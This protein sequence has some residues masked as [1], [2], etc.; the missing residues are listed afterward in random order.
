MW[1]EVRFRAGTASGHSLPAMGKPK[2]RKHPITFLRA[3]RKAGD[4][5]LKDAAKAIGMTGSNLAKIEKGEQPYT[6]PVL[7]ALAGFYGVNPWDLLM[8][9]PGEPEGLPEAFA[10]LSEAERRQVL[11]FV[12]YL[13]IS[14]KAA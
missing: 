11:Q 13:K 4:F 5:K 9:A 14:R 2:K 1:P 6:Q 10:G 7:E 8:R 12:E 3:Y